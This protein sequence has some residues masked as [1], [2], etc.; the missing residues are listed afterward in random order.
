MPN[1]KKTHYHTGYNAFKNDN[2]YTGSFNITGT[3]APGLNV[4][5][6]Q[7]TLREVPDFLDVAYNG[8]TDS[9]F[10]TDPR[11]ASGWFHQGAVWALGNNVPAGY[12]N[13]PTPW[14]IY[15][16]I[17]GTVLTI[18]AVYVQQFTAPLTLTPSPVSYRLV[19]Y[20]VF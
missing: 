8:A 19:D 1:L 13:Y 5:T 16:S 14:N 17:N 6:S 4:V 15:S 11:P 20:S 7:I 9:V 3:T 10:G 18:S 2:V 12:T